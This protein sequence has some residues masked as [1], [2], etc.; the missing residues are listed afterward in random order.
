M[1][2]LTEWFPFPYLI[3]SFIIY[4]GLIS[5]AIWQAPWF[6]LKNAVDLQV[7]LSSQFIVWFIWHMQAGVNAGL[8]FHLLLVT[9][10]TLMF[11]LPFAIIGTSLIQL[12]LTVEG[13]AQWQTYPLNILCNGIIPA[14]ISY[15][16]YWLVFLWL[17]RHFF[18]YIYAIAFLGGALSMLGSRLFGLA[19][20]LISKTYTLP[21]LG[22]EPLFIFVMLFPEAF[23]NGFLITILVVYRPQWVSSFSDKCYLQ[24]R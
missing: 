11:G 17:P 13:Q 14:L 5:W 3:G 22:E 4:I 12:G 9:T 24:G 10:I 21:T 15:G 20:L 2:F 8:E 16:I 7:F 18:I 6:Y 19:I 23:I 1:H